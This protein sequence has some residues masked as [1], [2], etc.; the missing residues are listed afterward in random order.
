MTPVVLTDASTIA[1][2]ASQSNHF[3]VTLGGNRTL[4]NPTNLRN[5]VIVNWKV[6]QDGTG[7]RTLA[8]GSKFKWASGTAPTLTTTASAVDY[9][10]GHYFSD[11]DI[12]V[13][14][15]IKDVR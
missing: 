14:A 13:A 11:D 2:D 12:I 10:S 3:T 7:S 4:G 15:I 9:I 6:K 1:T 8:Y 5:G